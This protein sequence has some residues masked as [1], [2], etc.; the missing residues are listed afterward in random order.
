M[1][2]IDFPIEKINEY[3]SDHIF[4]VTSYPL[5]MG[6]NETVTN[7]VKVKLT[8]VNN[9]IVVGNYT[10]HVEYTLYILPSNKQADFWASLLAYSYGNT[11]RLYTYSREYNEIT[12]VANQVVKNFLTMFGIN[13]QTI[14]TKVINELEPITQK[15]LNEGLIKEGRYD[16]VVRTIVRDILAIFKKYGE[17]EYGLPED[18][19]PE[20]VFYKFSQLINPIQ[21]FVDMSFDES[22][23]GF[24][25]DADYYNDEDLIYVT[26]QSNPKFS[27]TYLYDL[28]GELN[29]I[30]RHELEH[31]R[32]HEQGY[33]FPK[34]EPKKPVNYYT[35]QH[36]LDAQ[37]AGFKRRKKISGLDY[38]TVV[39]N[40]F[41]DNPHKHRLNSKEAEMVIRKILNEK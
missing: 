14:C 9:Y 15:K 37:R 4:N 21:V 3:L 31:V 40:W 32:Q 5:G 7:R 20:E 25:V 19:R 16:S 8:G 35:Q 38:E 27:Q 6:N 36:E 39:R 17:G 22:V 29:E 18:L 41:R 30:I 2:D 33:E 26:I 13:M 12:L 34:K 23:E 10:P 24:D 28:V 11:I 1:K